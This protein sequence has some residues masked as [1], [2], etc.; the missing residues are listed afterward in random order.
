MKDEKTT[1]PG[2]EF[3]AISA[4]HAA[5]K[6][7]DLAAQTRVIK[8]VCEVLGIANQADH[9]RSLN[10]SPME[11]PLRETV[12]HGAPPETNTD[13]DAEGI[14]PVAIKWMRRS[15]IAARDLQKLFSLGIDEIDL[16][17]KSVPG[18]SKKERLLNVLLLKAVAT[19]LGTG[20]PRVSHAQLKEA[21][22]HYDA[23]DN[24]N[25][26]SYI[27]S[28]SAE[29]GGSKASGYT[30]TARGITTAT[31]LVKSMLGA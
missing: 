16:V 1:N 17:A 26:A 4:V 6:E 29:V 18:G 12:A 15:G 31:E 3:G 9:A 22:I 28:F 23:Y 25:N 8:Y 14:S 19:Y 13:E 2:A 20:A 30:L 11:E 10:Y 7:L 5:L 24:A 21:S 27:K